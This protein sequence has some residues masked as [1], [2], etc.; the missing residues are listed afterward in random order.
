MSFLER[1][2]KSDSVYGGNSFT[3]RDLYIKDLESYCTTIEDRLVATQEALDKLLLKI[4]T[5]N[6]L[7]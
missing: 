6:K 4:E 3:K 5:Y 2:D 1:P 7:G